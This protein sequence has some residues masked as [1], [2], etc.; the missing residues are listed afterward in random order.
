MPQIDKNEDSA[1]D[2]QAHPRRVAAVRPSVRAWLCSLASTHIYAQVIDDR[3]R[4]HA[5]CRRPR[6]KRA[7]P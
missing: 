1:A 7:R 6:T 2:S 4:P 3:V 5:A